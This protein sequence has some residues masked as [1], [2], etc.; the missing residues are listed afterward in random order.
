M[1]P[2]SLLLNPASIDVEPVQ[3]PEPGA[4][5]G[6]FADVFLT[7]LVDRPVAEVSLPVEQADATGERLPP[8]GVDL[9]LPGTE[10]P[11]AV[12]ATRL[13]AGV[14]EVLPVPLERDALVAST[15]VEDTAEVEPPVVQPVRAALQRDEA[16]LN[17]P[18]PGPTL[19]RETASIASKAAVPST[20][21]QDQPA[22]AASPAPRPDDSTSSSVGGLERTR[23]V[24]AY[25]TTNVARSH[26]S[27]TMV[28]PGGPLLPGGTDQS[29]IAARALA[30]TLSTAPVQDPARFLHEGPT[31]RAL[32]PADP[33]VAPRVPELPRSLQAPVE[34][35][36]TGQTAAT[37][38]LAPPI[39]EPGV[40]RPLDNRPAEISRL[41]TLARQALARYAAPSAGAE[42]S[43]ASTLAANDA[44][45]ASAVNGLQ[46][47]T[48]QATG[49]SIEALVTHHGPQQGIQPATPQS[50][51]APSPQLTALD[52]QP[53]IFVQ[54]AQGTETSSAPAP[55]ATAADAWVTAD[56]ELPGQIAQRVLQSAAQ[57]LSQLRIQL[58]PLELGQLDI[59]FKLNAEQLELTFTAQHGATRELIESYLPNLRQLLSDSG[60]QLGDVDVKHGSDG[61]R[62]QA[63]R[64]SADGQRGGKT[65]RTGPPEEDRPNPEDALSAG[66]S[67][68]IP[69][70]GR[71]I[72]AFV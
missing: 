32:S 29:V 45:T 58:H 36:P 22:K 6:Q 54:A 53:P 59:H 42:L 3:L 66:L 64:G 46:G 62:Q 26:M 18:G 68:T 11:G 43:G 5:S 60:I 41:R 35:L 23:Q 7:K 16:V 57:N 27:M 25:G 69:E 28:L 38:A 13:S 34:Q 21:S 49:V 9:P 40:Q 71:I 12:P 47:F 67:G 33:V 51:S 44:R 65:D 70:Q 61:L 30:A 39:S 24:N 10:L 72:D 17:L 50:T 56:P 15:V 63:D 19:Q 20:V 31:I 1:L 8:P 4:P 52:A 14:P 37:S 2:S 48:G 55:R